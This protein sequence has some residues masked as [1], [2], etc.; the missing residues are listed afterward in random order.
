MEF[1]DYIEP[2]KPQKIVS[3]FQPT[4]ILGMDGD[5][6]HHRHPV[7]WGKKKYPGCPGCK[8]KESYSE[9]VIAVAKERV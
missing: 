1:Q 5:L 6:F 2:A 9:A 8:E 3:R 7:G 4:V